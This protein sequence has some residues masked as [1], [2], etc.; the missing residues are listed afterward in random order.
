MPRIFIKTNALNEV[1]EFHEYEDAGE[2]FMPSSEHTALVAH[3]SVGDV[4]G[5]VYTPNVDPTKDGEFSEEIAE[6][7]LKKPEKP[8]RDTPDAD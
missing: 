7:A 5:R 6:W 4:I 2:A 1:T 8:E 3:P